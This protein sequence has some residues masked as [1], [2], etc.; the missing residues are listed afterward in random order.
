MSLPATSLGDWFSGS[1]K[2]E[3]EGVGYIHPKGENSIA[4]S[5]L[6]CKNPSVHI[7]FL[8]L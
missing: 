3:T 8:L 6:G 7:S 1:R 4:V 2:D 5:R